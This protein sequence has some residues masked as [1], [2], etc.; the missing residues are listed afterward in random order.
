[1]N[2][3]RFRPNAVEASKKTQLRIDIQ[4]RME[5]R[6]LRNE[7]QRNDGDALNTSFTNGAIAMLLSA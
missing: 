7:M 6:E 2:A 1:V 5:F 4:N 3:S